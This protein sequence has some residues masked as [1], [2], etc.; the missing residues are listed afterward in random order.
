MRYD[1][2]IFCEASDEFEHEQ[3]RAQPLHGMPPGDPRAC[4]AP[5]LLRRV[6]VLRLL[7]QH[8]SD[9]NVATRARAKKSEECKD[10][11]RVTRLSRT[12]PMT[13]PRNSHL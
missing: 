11:S 10:A 6:H 4:A 5:H 1:L 7:P 2:V 9:A 12:R 13:A 3:Q 8:L